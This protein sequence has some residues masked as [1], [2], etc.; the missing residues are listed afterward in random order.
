MNPY[1]LG[2]DLGQAQDFT[3]LSLVEVV[4]PEP[5]AGAQ[6]S[7]GR[8]EPIFD[9]R[10]LERFPLRTPYPEIVARVRAMLQTDPLKGR[11]WTAADAT[12]VGAPV[13]DLLTQAGVTPLVAVTITGGTETIKDPGGKAF[14]VPKRDLVSGLQVLLQNHRL[15][16]AKGLP[17]TPTLE[18]ELL[19]F[20]V[21]ISLDTGHDSYG[22]PWREGLHDD[23]VLCVALSCWYGARL[24]GPRQRFSIARTRRP[25]AVRHPGWSRHVGGFLTGVG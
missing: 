20:Q 4:R 25:A 12:G 13:I 10:H 2:L 22:T 16:I 21:K 18:R 5:G 7:S 1:V 24:P 14:R 15:R 8:R 11:T 19:N 3:A 9:V 23:L 6:E 17:E